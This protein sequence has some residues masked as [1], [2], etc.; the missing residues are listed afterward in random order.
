[1][2]LLLA[3]VLTVS[4]LLSFTAVWAQDTPNLAPELQVKIGDFGSPQDFQVGYGPQSCPPEMSQ[5]GKCLQVPWIGQ[6]IGAIYRYG[7][8]FAAVLAML[9]ITIGGVLW[10]TSA[11][12]PER[13]NSAKSFVVSAITGLGLALFSFVILYTVNP[14]LVAL[15]PLVVPTVKDE[16]ESQFGLLNIGDTKARIGYC[17]ARGAC[18]PT[19]DVAFCEQDGGEFISDADYSDRCSSETACICLFDAPQT[20]EAKIFSCVQ[21]LLDGSGQPYSCS[22]FSSQ[23]AGVRC[24][25]LYEPCPNQSDSRWYNPETDG[26]PSP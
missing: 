9:M 12:S 23:P 11:G 17:A 16:P 8:A 15:E 14:R 19:N 5:T 18:Y 1:M 2:K 21:S 13:V 22:R 3:I 20:G 10:L 24:A 7:V 4:F 25:L 26:L 6:Y